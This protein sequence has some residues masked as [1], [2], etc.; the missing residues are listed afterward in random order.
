MVSVFHPLNFQLAMSN[1]EDY[2]DAPCSQ[3]L[4]C[5]M[6]VL[7]TDTRNTKS[8]SSMT[9]QTPCWRSQQLHGQWT[10]C[11]CSQQTRQHKVRVVNDNDY[12]LHRH[13]VG[14]VTWT[15]DT[16]QW[17]S[18]QCSQRLCRHTF[19]AHIFTKP[20]NHFCLFICVRMKYRFQM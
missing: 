2:A 6:S 3:R 4:H 5:H 18:C 15:L 13:C 16:G 10:P 12:T 1:Y 11:P 20:Q 19:F 7:S 17:T 8:V 14:V 9:I